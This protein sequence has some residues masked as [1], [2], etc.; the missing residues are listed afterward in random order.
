MQ[1][2]QILNGLLTDGNDRSRYEKALYWEYK[3][4]IEEGSRKY[5]LSN[6]DSF[7]AYSDAILSVIR[8]ISTQS[9]KNESSLKTYLFQIFS[10]K[11]IDLIRKR[12]TNKQKVNQSSAEPELLSHLPD[13]TKGII[14]KMM[15]EQK[16]M[17]IKQY[18]EVIGEKCKEI[19]LLF[20]DG[21]TD[22]QIAR[23]LVYSNAAVA[24]TTRLRCLEKIKEKMKN[25][26]IN[27]E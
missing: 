13:A 8:N 3:Y 6:D 7:S 12:T 17:A 19:L 10:N 26:F 24:K 22:D 11:C 5:Q 4:F 27:H 16:L 1:D 18:L 15:D 25:I 14:E 21:Y 2:I 20:E 23:K 9:F